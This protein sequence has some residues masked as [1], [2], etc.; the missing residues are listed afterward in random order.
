MTVP[1]QTPYN[2][3]L[4]NGVTN[5]FAYTFKLLLAADLV[6]RVAGVELGS[7]FTITG[8]GN[9][10]GGN[11]VF[12][13]PPANLAE[14]EFFS[15][16]QIKRETD[17]QNAGEFPAATVNADIDRVWLA[18]RDQGANL[19]RTLHLPVSGD[20]IDTMLPTPE[21]NKLLAWNGDADG[22]ENVDGA[23][24][25]TLVAY[26]TARTDVFVGDGVTTDFT[27]SANPVNINN[28]DVAVNR[29]VQT[30]GVDY[31]WTSG[32]TLSFTVAPPNGQRVQARFLQGLPFGELPADIAADTIRAAN[33]L[34]IGAAGEGQLQ[35]VDGSAGSGGSEAGH[36]NFLRKVTNAVKGF[37]GW[38][39]A[40]SIQIHANAGYNFLFTGRAP[41]SAI[42][43]TFSQD[44]LRL[45]DL[46]TGPGGGQY[47]HRN[48]LVNGN[49]A[50][51]Q[52]GYASGFPVVGALT[53]TL[54]M[55]R[56]V[57][58]GQAVTFANLGGGTANCANQVTA[59]A[60]GLEQVVP[61]E[62]IQ[63][64]TYVLSWVGAGTAK[65]NNVAVVNG[66]PFTLP[67]GLNAIVQFVGVV[68]YAQLEPGGTATTF[69]YLPYEVNLQRC[70]RF[71]EIGEAVTNGNANAGQSVSHRIHFRARK[72]KVPTISHTITAF[73]NA[74][75]A[76]ARNPSA[77]G[78][79]W[80]VQATVSGGT[81]STGTWTAS[82]EP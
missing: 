9:G 27:L 2:S 17:Y 25:A 18:L 67:A 16:T 34:T 11:V 82:A 58:S 71:Y 24:L 15:R 7:G 28:L 45:G 10:G 57:T 79:E 52:R 39:D 13:S 44:L 29:Q 47:S 64:G 50:V 36:I 55:W 19:A 20:A 65:V 26:G 59:P 5:T 68:S 56:V 43:P 38:G 22:L 66:V 23:G 46:A 75:V 81:A 33:T 3:H 62:N 63:G 40:S 21:A 6:V 42:A 41:R 51:N 14:I 8:L 61:G 30:P 1:V 49:F 76:E 35:L 53:Y 37:I 74:A 70:E 69:E 48:L 72:Y 78:L 60:G 77:D 4:G 12:V 73:A 80:Y 54:D 32:T 31:T